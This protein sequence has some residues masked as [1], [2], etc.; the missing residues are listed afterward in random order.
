M[1]RT[2][3]N[4]SDRRGGDV[5]VDFSTVSANPDLGHDSRSGVG[6]SGPSDYVTVRRGKKDRKRVSNPSA[7][8]SVL[9]TPG[10][11]GDP[12]TTPRGAASRVDT[13]PESCAP[14]RAQPTIKL[15]PYDGKGPLE[16]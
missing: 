13:V 10:K 16:G 8:E 3:V 5:G 12:K 2:S 4:P 14:R 9:P 1:T 15:T 11:T 6:F 7:P